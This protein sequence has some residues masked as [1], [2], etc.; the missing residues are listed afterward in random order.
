MVICHVGANQ[1][2]EENGQSYTP[3]TQ[4]YQIFLFISSWTKQ[5]KNGQ[6]TFV[7]PDLAHLISFTQ[8]L[9]LPM[10]QPRSALNCALKDS[11]Q[12]F[13][14]LFSR[15]WVMLISSRLKRTFTIQNRLHT[16]LKNWFSFIVLNPICWHD[17]VNSCFHETFLTVLYY[18]N[19]L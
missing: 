16:N 10:C 18:E 4:K 1:R 15:T 8:A 2:R 17:S 19:S 3:H 6:Q 5:K 9:P 13:S 12:C 7:K 11:A 14:V